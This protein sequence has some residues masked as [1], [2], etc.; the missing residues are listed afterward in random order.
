MKIK[1]EEKKTREEE[2]RIWSTEM[3]EKGE[4]KEDT[5]NSENR[6]GGKEKEKGKKEEKEE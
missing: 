5:K 3:I 2:I 1:R 4:D 6:Q